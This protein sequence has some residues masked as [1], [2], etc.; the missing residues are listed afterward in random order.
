MKNK[1]AK[2]NQKKKFI[3]C[4][5]KI[6]YECAVINLTFSNVL[7]SCLSRSICWRGSLF[8]C[9]GVET[10]F[11]FTT[12]EM[13]EIKVAFVCFFYGQSVNNCF[14]HI[15]LLQRQILIGFPKLDFFLF[16]FLILRPANSQMFTHTHAELMA[17][18]VKI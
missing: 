3:V 4:Q 6:I 10:D 7:W 11:S 2:R 8:V 9:S 1:R 14:F 15:K 17:N 13:R 16:F 12:S 5:I 18:N